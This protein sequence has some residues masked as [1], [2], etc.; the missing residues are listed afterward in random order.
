[1]NKVVAGVDLHSNNLVIGVMDSE[2]H[3]LASRKVECQLNEVVKFL[4]PFKKRLEQV[5]VESNDP[6]S[7]HLLQG[8][9]VA[10]CFGHTFDPMAQVADTGAAQPGAQGCRGGELIASLHGRL[11]P[12]PI[13]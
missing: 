7:K 12:N 9:F 13:K 1:M 6:R 3:R 2:G 11:S 4:S 10:G 5:A 8:Q